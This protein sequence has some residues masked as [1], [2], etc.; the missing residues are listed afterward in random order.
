M[1]GL[2]HSPL[3]EANRSDLEKYLWPNPHDPVLFKELCEQAKD[4]FEKTDYVIGA[5]SVKGG[6]FTTALQIRRYEQ[7]LMDLMIGV[8]VAETLLDKI[9]WLYQEMWTRYL[10]AVEPYVQIVH[11]TDDIGT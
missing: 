2:V 9:L 8:E 4:L 10:K 11:F 7:F 5:D 3:K 1:Y 6:I